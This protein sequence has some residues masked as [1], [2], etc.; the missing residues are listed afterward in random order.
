MDSVCLLGGGIEGAIHGT[1]LFC[2]CRGLYNAV[3]LLPVKQWTPFCCGEPG[4]LARDLDTL[5]GFS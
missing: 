4:L 2:R 3:K 1:D 5:M